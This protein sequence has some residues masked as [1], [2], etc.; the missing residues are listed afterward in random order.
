MKKHLFINSRQKQ[1]R[2]S[3]S[4]SVNYSADKPLNPPNHM[5]CL[6]CNIIHLVHIQTQPPEV[7]CKERCSLEFRK[8]HTKTHVPEACNFIKK[9]WLVQVF[10]CEFCEISKSSFFTEHLWMTASACCLI[11]TSTIW[12]WYE[13]F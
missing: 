5:K 10:S 1:N 12:Y 11:Y 7:L 8:I 13:W 6:F 9:V 3:L 4:S 2:I